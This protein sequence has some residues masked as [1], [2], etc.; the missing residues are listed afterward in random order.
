[1]YA[2]DIALHSIRSGILSQRSFTR[3]GVMWRCLGVLVTARH[4]RSE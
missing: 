4:E 1:M 2:S 3:T